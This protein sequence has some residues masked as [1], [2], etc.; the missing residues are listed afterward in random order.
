MSL[1]YSILALLS[2]L[3]FLRSHY[4]TVRETMMDAFGAIH[5]EHAQELLV[6]YILLAPKPSHKL[7]KRLFTQF[8]SKDTLPIEVFIVLKNV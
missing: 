8:I 2:A 1:S 6:N 3:Y 4:D 5:S 7:A